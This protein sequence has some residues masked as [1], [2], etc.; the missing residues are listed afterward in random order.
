MSNMSRKMLEMAV[1][2]GYE[3]E[4]VRGLFDTCIK[5]KREARKVAI[6]K[7]G[8]DFTENNFKSSY[9]ASKLEL[10]S[11]IASY[12]PFIEDEEGKEELAN[13]LYEIAYELKNME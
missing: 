8:E 5:S 10:A 7:L 2:L 4:G 11:V 6:E 12:K 3:N 9:M 1:A 13:I